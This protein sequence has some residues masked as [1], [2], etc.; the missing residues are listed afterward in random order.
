MKRF[1][2]CFVL[3]VEAL[4]AAGVPRRFNTVVYLETTSEESANV[5]IGDLDGDGDLDLVLAKGR[6]TPLLDRVLLNDRKG[7]FVASDLGPISDRTYTAALAD[8]DGDGDLDVLT[9]N[10]TP[11]KKLVYLNNG[12]VQFAVAGT[13]GVAEW[14]TRNAAVADLNGDGRVDVIAANRPG[15]SFVCLNQGNGRFTAECIAIPAKSATSIVPGDF[16]K[17][18]FIDLAVPSRDGGQSHIYFNDGKAGFARTTPFGPPDAAARVAAAADFN[19]DTSLDLVVGDEKASSMVVYQND[20]KGHLTSGFRIA[21]SART[22]YAIAAGDLNNDRS[23]DIV[24]GYTSGPHSIFFNDGTGR[25]F[26]EVTF[27]DPRG[28]AYGF[29]LGDINGDK[30]PD[31]ALARSGAPNVLYLSGK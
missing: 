4:A 31:I 5:S 12:K 6:H 1:S 7:G 29:A 19:G 15:P 20:G 24:L 25:H 23:P 2:V 14:S 9:S 28:A 21:N 8:V 17:D 16:D 30:F 18:G 26:T 10:D 22:P 13:W 11:D 3:M 27:G